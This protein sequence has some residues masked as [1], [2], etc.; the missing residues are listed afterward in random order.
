VVS[1]LDLPRPFL[2]LK[3]LAMEDVAKLVIKEIKA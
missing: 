2:K 3:A 1:L